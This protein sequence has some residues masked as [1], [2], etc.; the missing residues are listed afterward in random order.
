MDLDNWQALFDGQ[1]RYRLDINDSRVKADVLNFRGREALNTPFRWRIEF[2]TAQNDISARDVLLKYAT[3]SMLSGRVVQGVITRFEWLGTTDDQSHY[4]VT[5]SSRLTLLS[6]T[7][8]CAIYQDVSV[9]ELVERVL[10]AHGL[11]GAD[12]EFR[13]ERD[14]PQRELITQWRETDLQFIQRILSEVGIWF[15]TG[16]NEVT[17]LDTVTFADSQLHYQ[18]D[19]HLPYREPSAL[20][21]GAVEAVWDARTWHKTVTGM[22]RTRDYN[23]RTA[24]TP[25]DSAVTVRSEALTTGEQY[26]YGAPFLEAGDDSTSEPDTESGAFYARIHHE[27]ELNNSA[28]LHLFSNAAHLT[29]GMVLEAD[30][31]GLNALKDGMV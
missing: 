8:R 30:G 20:Y 14:Y 11:E 3:L 4:A 16:V 28:R 25:M 17:G 2:T 15:R 27:R 6:L 5:L 24:T 18:F 1:T 23:Y 9:P 26:R 10:R 29:P 7:R 12:F 31:A 21:D 22:V 13:L 19:V